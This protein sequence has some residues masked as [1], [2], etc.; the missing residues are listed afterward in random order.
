MKLSYYNWVKWIVKYC[1]KLLE[2]TYSLQ[3]TCTW[4]GPRYMYHY[5]VS[6]YMH[7]E[8]LVVSK[9]D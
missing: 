9:I 7:P 6:Q 5:A 3:L 8:K 1:G 2:I 4:S